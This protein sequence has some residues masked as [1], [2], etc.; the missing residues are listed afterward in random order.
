MK[1]AKTIYATTLLLLLTS[2]VSDTYKEEQI[3]HIGNKKLN[4][5]YYTKPTCA[6]EV[7]GY[8][9][10]NGFYYTKSGVFQFMADEAKKMQADAVEIDYLDQLDIKEYVGLGK[11]IRCLP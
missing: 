1:P 7:I 3:T 11:A 6:Y 10:V 4:V 8:I 2:C 9:E 5:F